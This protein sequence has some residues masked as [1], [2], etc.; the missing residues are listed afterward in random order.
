MQ[1]NSE[2][3]A[4]SVNMTI[5]VPFGMSEPATVSGDHPQGRGSDQ[6]V[7]VPDQGGQLGK[8]QNVSSMLSPKHN[9][10]QE[11]NLPIQEKHGPDTSFFN[12]ISESDSHRAP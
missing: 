12:C 9:Y 7:R 4:T 11:Q 3:K 6:M 1:A 8:V 10:K 5:G 2:Q